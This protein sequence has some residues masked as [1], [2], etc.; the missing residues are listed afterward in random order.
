MKTIL[1]GIA[2]LIIASS[3]LAA[4]TKQS[5]VEFPCKLTDYRIPR[6][7]TI[8]VRCDGVNITNLVADASL[9]KLLDE[10]VVYPAVET[11]QGAGQGPDPNYPFW[12]RFSFK[13]S[14]QPGEDYELRFSGS[15]QIK[16]PG[17][18]VPTK[19]VFPPT[20]F[21]FTTRLDL[22]AAKVVGR[23][24]Q[25]LSS[26]YAVRLAGG[27]KLI[28]QTNRT[29][30]ALSPGS[31]D[32]NDPDAVGQ[33]LLDPEPPS[34]GQKLEVQGVT[35]VFGRTPVVKP[36]KAAPPAAAPK[37]KDAANWYLNFLHQSGE[38]AKPTWIVNVKVAP[39]LRGLPGGFY[40]T[41]S[42]NVDTGNGQVGQT[43]T[44]D[45]INPKF[46]FT[47]LVRVR[48]GILEAMK[49]VPALSYETNRK[50]DKRNLLFDGDWRFYLKGLENTKA[51]RSQDAF[52]RARLLDPK[53]LPQDV[54]K[55][56]FGYSIQLLLGTEIGN[57]LT[58]NLVKS[59]D[60]SSQVTVPKYAIRRLRPHMS[61][62][63]ELGN[64]T[65]SL[66]VYP[67]YLFSAENV[68]R[69]ISTP[70]ADGK[71]KKTILL[72]TVSDWRPYGELSLTYAFDPAGHYAV[73]SVYKFGSQP[74]NFD[75][76]NLVQSGILIRF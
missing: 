48:A 33:I 26:H 31:G 11:R 16:R 17:N 67:R 19:E 24:K 41:P 39:V 6:P 10:S 44:N 36:A 23:P 72:S 38:G 64:F 70:Q 53:I 60:K 12:L 3:P 25:K 18:D 74:P 65:A 66:S 45:I 8:L 47:R 35:D 40:L 34:L 21:R 58:N 62:T 1:L 54:P 5:A 75:H 22:A 68:T 27:A 56:R 4:Q 63:L 20:R 42:L 9:Y 7:D 43:K 30:Y 37:S 52:L 49:F 51:E 13:Q 59:S 61:G 57:S 50:R 29:E 46:G 2:I 69:E 32:L 55:A 76:T 73:T 28:D 71:V 15:Y 14:L